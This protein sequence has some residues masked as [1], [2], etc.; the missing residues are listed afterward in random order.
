MSAAAAMHVPGLFDSFLQGGFECST[1]RRGDGRRLDLIAATGHDRFA[2]RDYRALHAAGLRTVRDGVRWHR[3]ETRPGHYDWSSL[4]PQVRAAREQGMQVVWDLCHYG[5]PDAIDIWRPE[6]VARFAA[7]AGAVARL[8]REE[9][10]EHPFFCPVNEISFWAWGGGEHSVMQPCARGRGLELKQQLV[11]ASIAAIEALRAVN[12]RSRLVQAEP[13]INVIADPDTPARREAAERRRLGQ[14]EAFD[15]LAGLAWPGLGGRPDCLDI[16]GV[17]YYG[18]NQWL[19]GGATVERGDPR[20][21]SLRGMLAEVHARYRRP[22]LIAETGAEGAQRVSWLAYVCRE[23][24]E[25]LDRGIPIEGLCLYPILDYPGW[26]DG[27][28]CE[29][30]LL[31]V[32]DATGARPVYRPLAEALALARRRFPAPGNG[33]AWSTDADAGLPPGAGGGM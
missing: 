14:F 2:A 1:H 17:N 12:P 19:H 5:W 16:V 28:H 9:G 6:F 13:L 22:L 21:R 32:A 10:I 27:R 24:E 3:I 23:V 26:E 20:Y 30:G 11:R 15:M 33:G 7:F 18:Y 8:L 31:G 4:L 25:A 29:V